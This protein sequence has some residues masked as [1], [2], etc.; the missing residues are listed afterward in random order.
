MTQTV[1]QRPADAGAEKPAQTGPRPV[2]PHESALLTAAFSMMTFGIVA[3]ALYRMW[4][5]PERDWQ[6]IGPVIAIEIIMPVFAIVAIC[7][8]IVLRKRAGL[9]VNPPRATATKPGRAVAAA[10]AQAPTRTKDRKD[11]RTKKPAEV[12]AAVP[13]QA[14]PVDQVDLALDEPQF[15][16][17][18]AFTFVYPDVPDELG[19]AFQHVMGIVR[20][21]PAYQNILDDLAARHATALTDDAFRQAEEFVIGKAERHE[22]YNPNAYDEP[23][24][25]GNPALYLAQA[26]EILPYAAT[27]AAMVLI[28]DQ[29]PE[30]VWDL[31]AKPWEDVGLGL[32]QVVLA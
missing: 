13:T 30:R 3:W 20:K 22:R 7:R 8:W 21:L 15:V 31:L 27:V 32:P 5:R 11:W 10:P 18:V 29:L 6:M 19:E 4:E 1:E 9:P 14:A 24:A 23:I 26:D 2:E 16:A 25:V 17:Q 12:V 28:A